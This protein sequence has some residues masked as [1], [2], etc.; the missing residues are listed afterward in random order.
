[1]PSRDRKI[2]PTRPTRPW[3]HLSWPAAV[4]LA[5][6]CGLGEGRLQKTSEDAT[7]SSSA[8]VTS[9]A[10]PS[11]VQTV[12]VTA[13]GRGGTRE[14]AIRDAVVRA[15]E[16][17]HGRA[18]SVATVRSDLGSV[19]RESE[20]RMEVTQD[21]K[22]AT[23]TAEGSE[24][25]TATLGGTQLVESTGGLVTAIRIT[26]EKQTA[27][28][29]EVTITASV[30]RFSPPGANKLS[31]VVA[32][33]RASRSTRL[34]ESAAE[35]IRSQLT[36]ALGRTGRL[37]MLDRSAN[38]A[39]EEELALAGSSASPSAEALKQGQTRVADVVVQ[40]D[41]SDL[42]VRRSARK[43]RTA[44][45]EIV[46]YSGRAAASFRVTHVATRQVLASGNAEATRSSEASLRDDVD[47]RAWRDEMIAEVM[48]DLAGQVV[49]ALVPIRVVDRTGLDVT[50][51]AGRERLP[52]GTYEVMVMGAAVID[53]STGEELGRK[54]R[55]CCMV[56]VSE[57]E[58]QISFG[59]LDRTPVLASGEMLQ[60]R[61]RRGP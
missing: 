23:Q 26:G 19:R 17:V 50:L 37:A 42:G 33:P 58:G 10:T 25:V 7:A 51:N 60:V 40:V 35:L 29:A 4:L 55:L 28:G 61:P 27:S 9:S 46:S 1:M 11:G 20:G 36:D 22:R 34:E 24:E 13:T 2:R 54:Q 47:S 12:E 45:K 56:T 18:I 53:P 44:D 43:M 14:E 16:Q 21:G 5:G 15:V 48:D 32:W 59:T 30:A 39:V 6:A 41:V 49:D 38:E 3:K 57:G 31:V 8:P 52:P